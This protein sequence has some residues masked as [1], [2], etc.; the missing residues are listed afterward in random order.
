MGYHHLMLLAL[1]CC[2]HLASADIDRRRFSNPTYY[3]VGGVLSSNESVAFF[4]DTISVSY[5][6]DGGRPQCLQLPYLTWT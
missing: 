3:N 5:T 4:K 1:W 2:G 6:Y